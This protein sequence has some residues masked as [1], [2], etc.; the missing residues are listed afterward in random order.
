LKNGLGAPFWFGLIA[1]AQRRIFQNGVF[2]W[3]M[4]TNFALQAKM[5]VEDVLQKWPETWTV[6]MSKRTYCTGCFIQRFCSLQDVAETYQIPLEDLLGEL[7]ACVIQSKQS[8]R[9]TI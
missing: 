1:P 9:S 8:Q 3:L 2:L 5:T 6:F 4:D 7:E